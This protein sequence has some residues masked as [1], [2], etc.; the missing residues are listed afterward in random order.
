MNR[1]KKYIQKINLSKRMYSLNNQQ[2]IRI[3]LISVVIISE[4]K[5]F[6][7]FINIVRRFWWFEISLFY[8]IN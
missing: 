6:I 4:I 8:K 1:L 3:F 2:I 7:I 5:L